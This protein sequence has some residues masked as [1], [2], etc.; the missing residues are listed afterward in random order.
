MLFFNSNSI[1]PR[2]V[3]DTAG[4][5]FQR[6]NYV[7]SYLTRKEQ[8]VKLNNF[9]HLMFDLAWKTKGKLVFIPITLLISACTVASVMS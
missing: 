5:Q 2:N 3:L 1:K 9:F 8:K 4:L 7:I 6:I